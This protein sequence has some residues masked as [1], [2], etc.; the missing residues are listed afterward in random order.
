MGRVVSLLSN[1]YWLETTANHRKKVVPRTGGN[2]GSTSL[3][4]PTTPCGRAGHA[5]VGGAGK[6]PTRMRRGRSAPRVKMLRKC[7]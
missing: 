1:H 7:S 6:C 5:H 3:T 2:P 4:P